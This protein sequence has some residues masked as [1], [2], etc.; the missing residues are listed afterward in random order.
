MAS[1]KGIIITGAILA[2]IAA[3]SFMVWFMPQ[4]HGSSFIVSDYGNE[5]DSVMERHSL[6]SNEVDTDLKRLS[7][8][9][10]SSDD[11]IVKA[12][13]SSSQI[14]SLI[15]ELIE[16]NPPSEWKQSYFNYDEA[17]KKYNDYLTE[18]ISF[19]NKMKNGISP[20][21]LSDEMSKIESIKKESDSFIVKSNETRP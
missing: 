10:L 20:N 9:T 11:Y 14:T 21:D 2:A 12:Q 4:N 18:T 19:A 17:L 8:K 15:T 3:A 5:L 7:N 16:S 6:I 1:K 13:V